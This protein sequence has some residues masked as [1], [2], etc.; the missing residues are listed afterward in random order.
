VSCEGKED[1]IMDMP[2][3]A[4][5]IVYQDVLDSSIDLDPITSQANEEDPILEP[6]WATSSSY[7]HVYLDDTFPSDEAIIC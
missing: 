5:K 4:A 3:L 7:S 6:M 2:L 1:A